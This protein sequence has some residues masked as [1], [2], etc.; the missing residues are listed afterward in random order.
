M[1]GNASE[2]RNIRKCI[3]CTQQHWLLR[4]R[5]F[6]EKATQERLKFEHKKGLCDNCLQVG[7]MAKSCPK[8][9]FCKVEDCR[10]GRKHSTLLHVKDDREKLQG[11]IELTLMQVTTTN[12]CIRW[13]S[14]CSSTGAGTIQATGMPIVPV[15]VKV[16]DSSSV[17]EV[18]A[19]LGQILRS[20][21]SV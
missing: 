3:L 11:N 17:V 15:W 13:V 5:A 8:E 16:K 1:P 4:C 18:Y 21:P 2:D 14:L 9:S 20:V 7:H 19:I 6:R 10:V 12:S